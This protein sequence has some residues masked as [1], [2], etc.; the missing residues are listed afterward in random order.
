[1]LENA[2]LL[3]LLVSDNSAV[4]AGGTNKNI[5]LLDEAPRRQ[6]AVMWNKQIIYGRGVVGVEEW[7]G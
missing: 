3:S 6:T 4:R 7:W 2:A 1:M 5:L